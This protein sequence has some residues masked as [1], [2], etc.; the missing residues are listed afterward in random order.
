M[1]EKNAARIDAGRAVVGKVV[2]EEVAKGNKQV[3]ET[4]EPILEPGEKIKA[5]LPGGMPVGTVQR[6]EPTRR[7]QVNITQLTAWVEK[8]RP[9]QL[10]TN[11][12]DAYLAHLMDQ[13]KRL[14]HAVDE[15]TGEIIP[16]IELVEGSSSFRITPSKEGREYILRKLA[17][18]A[19]IGILD[20]PAGPAE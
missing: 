8:N 17:E 7:V 2:A 9:D 6:T 5:M 20:L 11:V 1:T 13:C 18:L 3:R 16:G 4:V 12:A 19:D 14:G 15:T 10:Q